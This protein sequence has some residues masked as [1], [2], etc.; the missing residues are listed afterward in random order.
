MLWIHLEV[1]QGAARSTAIHATA[2]RRQ[3]NQ[4][5]NALR[6]LQRLRDTEKHED[7]MSR[8]PRTRSQRRELTLLGGKLVLNFLVLL[9]CCSW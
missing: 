7:L 6:I 8:P 9:Y 3:A 4:R 1:C 5:R 2:V